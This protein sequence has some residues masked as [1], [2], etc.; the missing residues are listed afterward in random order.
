MKPGAGSAGRAGLVMLL[1]WAAFGSRGGAHWLELLVPAQRAMYAVL[2][3]DFEVRGFGLQTQVAHLT[4]RA[5]TQNRGYLVAGGR[6]HAPGIDF[7]VETPARPALLYAVLIVVGA[8][9]TVPAAGRACALAALLSVAGAMFMAIVSLPLILAGEQ[10]G[11]AVGAGAEPTLRA[12]L[13][14]ASGFLLHG[15]GYAL[16]AAASWA[17]MALTRQVVSAPAARA[18]EH[19]Q[20]GEHHRQGGGL[21]HGAQ[22]E[23]ETVSGRPAGLLHPH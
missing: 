14:V 21:G 18:D 23:V 22:D 13:V 11:L 12:A 19:Q 15:G 7:E 17:I 16:C 1:L 10:W 9:V 8:L 4:L 2:M 20:P 5:V 6:A 3:P